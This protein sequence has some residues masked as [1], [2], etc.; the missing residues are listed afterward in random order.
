M[1]DNSGLIK[2]GSV[3]KY[4]VQGKDSQGV[5]EVQRRYNEFLALN[6]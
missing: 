3:V 6:E 4:V 5:F 1:E 2:V